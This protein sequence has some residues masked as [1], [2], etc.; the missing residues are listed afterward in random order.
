M[1]NILSIVTAC[2]LS[3]SCLSPLS[4]QDILPMKSDVVYYSFKHTTENTKK[5]MKDYVL[6]NMNGEG[7]GTTAEVAQ[8]VQKKASNMNELKVTLGGIKNTVVTFAPGTGVNS[9]PESCSGEHKLPNSLQLTLPVKTQLLESNLLFSLMTSGKFKVSGQM[10]TATLKV[11]F[12]DKNNYE[13]IFTNFIITYTGIKGTSL[14]TESIDLGEV[15]KK[16]SSGDNA[17]MYD[18][19]KKSLEDIDAIVKACAELYAKELKKAYE[20]DE[21]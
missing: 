20:L 13:I 14:I 11:R 4:A 1:K 8:N 3:V 17:K 2:F 12:T 16:I 7:M 19:S 5:C 9:D 10:V 21:L 6:Y 15:Q 18:N